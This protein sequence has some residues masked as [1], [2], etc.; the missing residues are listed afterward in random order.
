VLTGQA[1][2]HNVIGGYQFGIVFLIWALDLHPTAIIEG[3]EKSSPARGTPARAPRVVD[4]GGL[5]VVSR[6]IGG[7]DEV[8]KRSAS[9][10]V[11]SA[12]AV[13][14]CRRAGG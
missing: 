9:L 3:G 2:W 4:G 11:W 14:S 1:T 5:L 7:A 6:M 13:V 12:T 8:K 10:G